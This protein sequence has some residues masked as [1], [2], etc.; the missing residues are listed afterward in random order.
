MPVKVSK[1]M[2]T[3]AIGSIRLSDK[4]KQKFHKIAVSGE[5]MLTTSEAED[6]LNKILSDHLFRVSLN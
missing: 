2:S 4:T 6:I 1:Y 3:Q 5:R